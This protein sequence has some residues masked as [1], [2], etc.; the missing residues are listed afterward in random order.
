MKIKYNKKT[1]KFNL[2]RG[3]LWS[4]LGILNLFNDDKI[5]FIGFGFSL[6]GILYLFRFI[7]GLN[8]HYLTIE[9]GLIYKNNP[10]SKKI[11]L[12]EITWI[13]KIYDEYIL[14]T[15]KTEMKLKTELISDTSLTDLNNALGELSLQS[16]KT[17]FANNV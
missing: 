5:K 17:P 3:I 2:I 16:D 4:I 1:L 8:F 6:I 11:R 7:Y 10:F 12:T 9:N 14:I 13:K 15:K